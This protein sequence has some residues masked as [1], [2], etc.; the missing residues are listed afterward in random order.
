TNDRAIWRTDGATTE[1]VARAGAE[2]P[3]GGVFDQFLSAS[4]DNAGVVAVRGAVASGAQ[5][6]W[7][8]PSAGDG[9]I[10]A[11]TDIVGVPGLPLSSFETLGPDVLHTPGGLVAYNAQLA[12][13]GLVSLNNDRGVWLDATGAGS[14]LVREGVSP[15]PGVAGATFRTPLVHAIND[16][17]QAALL[18]AFA[19]GGPITTQNSQA[20]WRVSP[21][22][23]ELVARRSVGN[24][25]GVPGASYANLESVTINAAGKIAFGSELELGGGVTEGNRGIWA[26]DGEATELVVR[27]GSE[28][29][30]VPGGQFAAFGAP[31]LNDADSIL[32]A[33]TLA[34][35]VGGVTASN[36]NGLW[37]FH[38]GGSTLL[39]R[40]GVGG[41]PNVEE[42]HFAEFNSLALNANDTVALDAT[43]SAGVAGVT[44]AD[45]EGLWLFSS[46][47]NVMVAREGGALA[48]R[49]IADLE[50]A[51]GSG[52]GDGRRRALN[53]SDQLVFRAT[54]TN[55][56]EG[57]FLY[58]LE[59]GGGLAADFTA[60]GMVNAADL[61]RWR[62][63]FGQAA[64]ANRALGDADS[65]GD[66]DGGD[67]LAWQRQIGSTPTVSAIPEPP[68]WPMLLPLGLLGILRLNRTN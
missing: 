29:Q 58:N 27:S 32:T 3:G 64:D 4:I 56:D 14:L 59:A 49:T 48:G 68:V 23:G 63:N 41:V 12:P 9:P 20:I 11:A 65:D 31:L 25:A 30:G 36:A 8:F 28:P 2:A 18:G 51:G 22:G 50:F 35:G 44:E 40:T 46:A 37:M 7:R 60:D 45:N 19:T 38:A 54:F 15:A 57:L 43:L 13:E 10:V 67:F 34:P 26:S 39:A 62:A 55:G 1:V 66:V 33:A 21:T 42:A 47:G 53:D 61:L 52:G 16:Q 5:R 6:I 17:S 24:V